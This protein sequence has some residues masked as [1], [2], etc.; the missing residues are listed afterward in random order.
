MTGREPDESSTDSRSC[1]IARP[2]LAKN[3]LMIELGSRRRK[4]IKSIQR[5]SFKL[6]GMDDANLTRNQERP[7]TLAHTIWKPVNASQISTAR[8][9][10]LRCH[11]CLSKLE[12]FS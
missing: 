3:V 11:V 9:F 6:M 2:G 12:P 1:L 5:V 7:L 8:E 10:S 4:D